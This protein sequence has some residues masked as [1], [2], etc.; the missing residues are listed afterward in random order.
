MDHSNYAKWL[1]VHYRDLRALQSTHPSV[2]KYLI[3]GSFAVTTKLFS[4]IA[5][6]HC[7]EKVN[8]VVKEGTVGLTEN[9]AALRIWMVVGPKLS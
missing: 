8:A 6:D 4:S 1:S 2:Y 5:L 7:H 9:P 3:D